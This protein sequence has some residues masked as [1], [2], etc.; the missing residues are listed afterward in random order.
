M[1]HALKFGYRRICWQEPAG[2]KRGS[3]Q[4]RRSWQT[5]LF[6]QQ[7]K[8]ARCSFLKSTPEDLGHIADSSQRPESLQKFGAGLGSWESL[9]WRLVALWGSGAILGPLLDGRH[10]THNVLHYEN[11]TVIRLGS[12]F[13]LE[14]CW[15]VPLLFGGAAVILGIGHP[16]LDSIDRKSEALSQLEAT[17]QL[18][19]LEGGAPI[20]SFLRKEPTGGYAPSWSFVL[21]SIALFAMQYD[22]SGV[23]AEKASS[24]ELSWTAVNLA[25]A[26]TAI[27]HWATFDRTRSGLFWA[28]LTATVGP[29]VEIGL[30]EGLHLYHYTHP[31]VFGI[32]LWIPWVYWCGAPAVGNLGRC[33]Q[34][35]LD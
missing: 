13:Q 28:A 5:G 6:L 23:L 24:G 18:A 21:I 7:S 3:F 34:A 22:L 10:S 1:L 11:P 15:W 14:T 8:L 26:G 29:L 9:T 2:I 31:D 20:R 4:R 17:S 35:G 27:A 32:P 25:L 33:I 12:F 30:I 16:L 19:G